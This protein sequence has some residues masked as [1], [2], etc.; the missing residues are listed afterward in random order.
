MRK[1][2]VAVIGHALWTSR[3]ESDP[4]VRRFLDYVGEQ[5][6]TEGLGMDCPV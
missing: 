3:F 6:T 2:S 4:A 1:A 5:V